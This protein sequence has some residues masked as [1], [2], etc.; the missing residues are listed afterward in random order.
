MSRGFVATVTALLV[1]I[2]LAVTNPA[3]DR[4]RQ[5]AKDHLLQ[6]ESGLARVLIGTLFSQLLVYH[7]F[8]IG[9]YTTHEGELVTAGALNFVWVNE[10]A[11]EPLPNPSD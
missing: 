3:P 10:A 4:H 1:V 8:V 2:L 6:A 7:S 11:F 9:S 5:A